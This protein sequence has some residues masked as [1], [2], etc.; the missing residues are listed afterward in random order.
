MKTVLS[1][2]FT[3]LFANN[4][5]AAANQ[6]SS[7][8]EVMCRAK[9]KEIATSTYSTC[10]DEYNTAQV[11]SIRDAY[12]KDLAAMKAKY[13]KK[14]KALKK[15]SSNANA[16]NA[17]K[18]TKQSKGLAKELPAK[19][20]NQSETGPVNMNTSDENA[21][22]AHQASDAPLENEVALPDQNDLNETTAQ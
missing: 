16:N 5:F 2:V 8:G 14:L 10:M 9:A 11:K 3:I 12:Q 21:V 15:G 4:T 7:S 20:V 19:T 18:T 13:D 17:A 1:F 22:A 6:T